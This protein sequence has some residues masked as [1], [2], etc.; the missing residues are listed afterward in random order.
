MSGGGRI[1]GHLSRG[2]H[3]SNEL[4]KCPNGTA[5]SIERSGHQIYDMSNSEAADFPAPIVLQFHSDGFCSRLFA[6]FAGKMSFAT[7]ITR[8]KPS[9][10]EPFVCTPVLDKRQSC[11]LCQAL[12]LTL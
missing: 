4:F 5:R 12:S 6:L 3:L 9:S 2:L 8:L 7:D 1:T 10:T 11:S